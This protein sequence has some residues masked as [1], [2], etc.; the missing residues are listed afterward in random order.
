[1]KDPS[2]VASLVGRETR[3]VRIGGEAATSHGETIFVV[4]AQQASAERHP[5]SM[6]TLHFGIF[7]G[8]KIK[9]QLPHALWKPSRYPDEFLL[10]MKDSFHVHSRPPTLDC[11]LGEIW[12]PWNVIPCVVER[13]TPRRPRWH[14]LKGKFRHV[15][16]EFYHK[17]NS[18]VVNVEVNGFESGQLL[19]R[20][21]T[22]TASL[23][24]L[25][26][27]VTPS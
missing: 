24:Y 1:M 5:V 7:W 13:Q 22:K 4:V 11:Q 12:Y 6:L 23:M 3:V 25:F 14:E 16:P 21:H 9:F 8:C 15:R 20:F 26:A 19:C 27:N 18:S 17:V 10:V 2:F